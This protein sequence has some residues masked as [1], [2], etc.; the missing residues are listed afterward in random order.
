MEAKI[1][2]LPSCSLGLIRGSWFKALSPILLQELD[3]NAL[4]IERRLRGLQRVH[5]GLIEEHF[6]LSGHLGSPQHPDYI[7]V[8]QYERLSRSP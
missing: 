5:S 6:V 1:A 7:V 3:T 2:C 8:E 4:R